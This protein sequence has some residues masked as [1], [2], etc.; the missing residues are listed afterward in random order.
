[1]AT[2]QHAGWVF[3]DDGTAV[4]GA[5]VQLYEQG[6]TSSTVESSTVTASTGYWAL[7]TTQ[8]PDATGSYY[9]H[10]VKITSGSSIRYRRGLD[11]MQLAEM[12]IR[13]AT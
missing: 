7:T 8:E 13:N 5:T 9:G 4:V 2:I 10:D 12:D 3:K 6:S 11:R 1:M